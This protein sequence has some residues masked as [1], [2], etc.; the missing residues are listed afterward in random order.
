M[1]LDQSTVGI[2]SKKT[3]ASF[4]QK[5]ALT[6]NFKA[7]IL[8]GSVGISISHFIS[9]FG[10]DGIMDVTLLVLRVT[11]FE[12]AAKPLVPLRKPLL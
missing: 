9:V 8:K 3:A 5:H 7:S 1:V 11:P 10:D 6:F 12:L 4:I 2:T